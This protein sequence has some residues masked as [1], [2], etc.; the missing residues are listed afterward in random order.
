MNQL[1]VVAAVEIRSERLLL[2][3]ELRE[4]DREGLIDLATDPEVNAYLGG[5]QSREQI[6]RRLDEILAGNSVSRPGS[7]V[8]ADG[9]TNLP[10]G[11][12]HLSRRPADDPG[13]IGE[14]LELGYLL[15]R[16]AWGAGYAFEAITALLRA[17]AEE[18]PDQPVVLATQTANARSLKLAARLGFR[19]TR[20]FVAFDA[21]QALCSAE[22]SAFRVV[23]NG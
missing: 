22:L 6:E 23:G 15:R 5:P 21:E 14:D 12:L 17:A 13:H 7:Y 16:S 1:P 11:T 2:R 18:L 10:L 20:T 8:I 19:R 3:T 4:T 9:P